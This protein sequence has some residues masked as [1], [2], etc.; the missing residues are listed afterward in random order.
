MVGSLPKRCFFNVDLHKWFVGG[1]RRGRRE[2][3][4]SNRK[5]WIQQTRFTASLPISPMS[6]NQLLNLI[7]FLS[8][9]TEDINYYFTRWLCLLFNKCIHYDADTYQ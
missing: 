1:I 3:E 4:Q 5:L 9:L 8:P 6:V 7:E 2:T